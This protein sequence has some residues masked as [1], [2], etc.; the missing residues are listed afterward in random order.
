MY[1]PLST[2]HCCYTVQAG[3]LAPKG[4]GL[5]ALPLL[6]LE[7][8]PHPLAVGAVALNCCVGMKDVPGGQGT[9]RIIGAGIWTKSAI[10]PA[11]VVPAG[12]VSVTG[13]SGRCAATG[14]RVG[15]GT[16]LGIGHLPDVLALGVR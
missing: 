9:A 3:A 1:Q 13:I 5:R 6:L 4:W 2:G 8:P 11:V 10:E 16:G 15:D 12:W 14:D 7:L